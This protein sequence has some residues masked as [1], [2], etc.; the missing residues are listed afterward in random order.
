[1]KK[2]AIE[3]KKGYFAMQ[4]NERWFQPKPTGWAIFGDEAA[5]IA[6]WY[7]KDDDGKPLRYTLISM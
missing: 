2:W 7:C 3:T 1:M 6:Y 4:G 5:E